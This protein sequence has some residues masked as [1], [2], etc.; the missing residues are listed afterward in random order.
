M[1]TLTKTARETLLHL[2][3]FGGQIRCDDDAYLGDVYCMTW[4]TLRANDDIKWHNRYISTPAFLAIKPYL[5]V[6]DT[7]ELF[8][9][10]TEYEL[11]DAGWRLT[12]ELAVERASMATGGAR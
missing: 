12:D 2:S 7:D 10:W 3:R 8:G 1:T 4:G 11:N 6:L 5:K 9:R